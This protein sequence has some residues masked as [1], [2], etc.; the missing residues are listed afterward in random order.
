MHKHEVLISAE[1]STTSSALPFLTETPEDLVGAGNN[2]YLYEVDK[3]EV[4]VLLK[5]RAACC[6]L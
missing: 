1:I 5:D 6:T 3:E 2:A 4:W